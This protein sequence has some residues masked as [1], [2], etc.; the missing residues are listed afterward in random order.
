MQFFIKQKNCLGAVTSDVYSVYSLMG[1]CASS[2]GKDEGLG[3]RKGMGGRQEKSKHPRTSNHF[4]KLSGSAAINVSHAG[5]PKEGMSLHT[6][7]AAGRARG[8]CG[9]GRGVVSAAQTQK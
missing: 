2:G 4:W 8:V 3:E 6:T 5:V 9:G 7:M 1:A